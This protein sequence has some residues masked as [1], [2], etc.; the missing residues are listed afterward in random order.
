MKISNK[1]VM[2]AVVVA[3]SAVFVPDAVAQRITPDEVA[4]KSKDEFIDGLLGRMTVEEK[5]GQLNLPSYGNVRPDAKKSEIA[6]RISRGEV[7]GIFNIF[8]VEDIRALQEVAVEESRLGIPIIIGADI[9]QGYKT[10]FPVPLALSCSWKPENIEEVA[11][12][13][14]KSVV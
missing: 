3:L 2:S 9:C 6:G 7:G 5:I 13:D 1:I 10:T 12:I 14:R 11:R 4:D 8:G